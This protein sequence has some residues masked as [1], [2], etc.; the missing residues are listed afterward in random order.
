MSSSVRCRSAYRRERRI[1]I[2]NP[3]RKMGPTPNCRVRRAA[4]QVIPSR[5]VRRASAFG[6]AT[7]TVRT[8]TG[9]STRKS[10]V[11]LRRN[12]TNE[13]ASS[14]SARSWISGHSEKAPRGR[15]AQSACVCCRFMLCYQHTPLAAVSFSAVVVICSTKRR[16]KTTAR[17]VL[18]AE[19]RCR[20][21][22]KRQRRG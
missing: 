11:A 14:I 15:S 21:P 18:S 13:E 12:S 9:R 7:R 19:L 2:P 17:R 1:V 8:N 10:A 22:R 16:D 5:S 6:I 3:A 20:N 4:S